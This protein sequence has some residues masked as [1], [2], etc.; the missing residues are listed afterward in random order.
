MPVITY[1]GFCLK[2]FLIWGCS[3]VPSPRLG[4]SG[5]RV[6]SPSD[7][8]FVSIIIYSLVPDYSFLPSQDTMCSLA[9]ASGWLGLQDQEQVV[10]VWDCCSYSTSLARCLQSC[11]LFY[12]KPITYAF[13]L[14]LRFQNRLFLFGSIVEGSHRLDFYRVVSYSTISL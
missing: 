12:N 11:G 14:M 9:W 10:L 3:V 7:G 5:A 1:I 2:V 13:S 4:K 8:F 6:Q